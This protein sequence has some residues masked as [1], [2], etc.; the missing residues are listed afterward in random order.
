MYD[1]AVGVR[2]MHKL[3]NYGADEPMYDN[4]AYT[5]TSTYQD[6]R[7]QIYLT[8]PA[9]P[10]ASEGQP[11]YHMTKLNR[12]DMTGNLK[13]FRDGATAYRNNRDLAMTHRLSFIK[14]AN[15]KAHQMDISGSTTT[16][17]DSRTSLSPL[18][19]NS[20][21]ED[22]LARNEVIEPRREPP[23]LR[24]PYPVDVNIFSPGPALLPPVY[25]YEV[26][27]NMY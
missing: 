19:V 14:Q 4:K 8:H 11:E 1:G 24:Y 3:Q 25:R 7:L 13:N 21:T 26:G 12:Y 2:A 23:W 20:D 6:G 15:E 18:I 9:G 16:W 10:L 22:G 27:L 5:F 17:S